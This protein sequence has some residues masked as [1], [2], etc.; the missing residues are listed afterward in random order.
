VERAARHHQVREAGALE[1]G[2]GPLPHR[3]EVFPV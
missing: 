3:I 1:R 2:V